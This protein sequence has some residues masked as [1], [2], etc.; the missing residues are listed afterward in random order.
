MIKITP[1]AA[2]L[3]FK[4]FSPA[5]LGRFDVECVDDNMSLPLNG[6][7]SSNR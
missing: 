6:L 5:E 4:G 7:N 3:D 2:G 1:A